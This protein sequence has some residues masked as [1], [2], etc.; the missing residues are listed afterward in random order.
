MA[1]RDIAE[2][3]LLKRVHDTLQHC[4]LGRQNQKTAPAPS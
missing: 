4:M 3:E 1:R 2:E